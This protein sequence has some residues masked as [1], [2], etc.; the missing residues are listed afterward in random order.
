[1]SSRWRKGKTKMETRVTNSNTELASG[2]DPLVAYADA[3]S[4]HYVIGKLLRFSKGDYFAGETNEPVPIGKKFTVAADELLAGYVKWVS[5]KPVDHN[6]V[7]VEDGK[8]PPRRSDLGD[9]DRSTW[10]TDDHGEPRDPQQ[11][12]NYLPMKDENGELY[13]FATS[14]NGG[15]ATVANLVRR[16]GHHRKHHPDD[17]PIISLSVGSY[18]HKKKEY[19]RIK[20]PDFILVGYEPKT[21]FRAALEVAGFVLAEQP[22][23]PEPESRSV[24]S[25]PLTVVKAKTESRGFQM[26]E[27]NTDGDG[28]PPYGDGELSELLRESDERG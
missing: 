17:Y 23:P 16:Y 8:L 25:G 26:I 9:L 7:R 2:I 21:H 13:T 1:M 4:P 18:P 14:S 11:F 10:E 15:V 27:N 24:G 5:G 6:M 22:S 28:P 12:T 19:G 3:I 20:F